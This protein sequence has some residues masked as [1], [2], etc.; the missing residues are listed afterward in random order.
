MNRTSSLAFL[1]SLEAYDLYELGILVESNP[2]LARTADEHGFLPLHKAAW[3]G[4]EELAGRL[5]DLGAH[6]DARDSGGNTP[7]HLASFRGHM[8]MIRLLLARGADVDATEGAGHTALFAAVHD[9]NEPTALLLLSCG[10]RFGV[11]EGGRLLL[12][13]RERRLNGLAEALADAGAKSSAKDD[14]I[15]RRRG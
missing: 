6:M 1:E 3:A 14:D 9:G 2:T 15:F 12:A 4:D 10:A 5:L 13:A 8:A 11:A 7:M